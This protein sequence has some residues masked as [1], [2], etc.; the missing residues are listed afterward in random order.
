MLMKMTDFWV[1]APC[2]LAEVERRFRAAY[3]IHHYEIRGAIA[4]VIET[5]NTYETSVIFYET[6]L[7][8]FPIT[9][10]STTREP[11]ISFHVHRLE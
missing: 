3:C 2:S 8:I 6:T 7:L 1:T 4:Q 5:V 9:S 11:E 10:H